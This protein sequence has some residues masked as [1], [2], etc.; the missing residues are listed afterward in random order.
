[1]D[2]VQVPLDVT[3]D[4][5]VVVAGGIGIVALVIYFAIII[6]MI[7]SMWKMFAKAGQPGW[8][9]LV[10]IL[11]VYIMLQIAGKPGWWLLLMFIPIVSIVISIITSIAIA[12]N[13][14][15]GVGFGLGLAFLPIVFVPI[16]AFSDAQYSA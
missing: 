14:N 13:F 8:A 11:N 1:M 9:S 3:Y 6:F 15:K 4:T 16:L 7:V 5:S 10:P 2:E 12:E